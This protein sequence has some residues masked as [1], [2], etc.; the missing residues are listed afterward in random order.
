MYT[1]PCKV[2][3][4]QMDFI[5]DTGAT[6]VSI[7][8]TV[9]DSL[10]K[11]GL[12]SQNDIRGKVKYSIANGNT[13]EGTKIILKEIILDGLILENVEASIINHAAA[14]LLFGLSAIDKFGKV[15]MEDDRILI[16]PETN[17]FSY[18][19][20]KEIKDGIKRLEKQRDQLSSLA[21]FYYDRGNEKFNRGWDGK[22]KSDFIGAIEDYNKAI[23]IDKNNPGLFDARARIETHLK[24]NKE[25][26]ADFTKAIQLDPINDYSYIN[27][28]DVKRDSDDALGAIEDYTKAIE[29]NPNTLLN[30]WINRA[31]VKHS[32]GDHL[33]AI[34]DFTILID[35]V[36]SDPEYYHNRGTIKGDISD[37]LGAIEDETTAIRLTKDLSSPTFTEDLAFRGFA[38]DMIKNYNAAIEDYS[39]AIDFHNNNIDYYVSRARS[40]SNINDSKG[41]IEDYTKSINL[42][43]KIVATFLERGYEKTLIGDKKGACLDF[44]KAI[45][46]SKDTE[47]IKLAKDY[48]TKYCR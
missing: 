11:K 14:P 5:F 29:V 46:G 9:A 16:Y 15:V 38:Y 39:K 41:A 23:S 42:N 43:P 4:L 26:I 45:L 44:T 48:A 8:S 25:A 2:N 27:R 36:P 22:K 31:W 28:G 3:G 7:S 37:Y 17:W 6:D 21:R 13:E 33:G 47:V 10:I 34:D 18:N 19:T 24:R 12:L 40:K 35:K 30:A 32:I 1:L 20:S